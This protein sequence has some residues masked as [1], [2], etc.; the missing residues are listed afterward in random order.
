MLVIFIIIAV[1]SAGK[2]LNKK[3]FPFYFTPNLTQINPY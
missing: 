1:F 3:D 2:T